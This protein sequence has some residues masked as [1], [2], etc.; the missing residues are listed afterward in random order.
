VNHTIFSKGMGNDL[1]LN[2]ASCRHFTAPD[3]TNE[4]FF[5]QLPF[6]P[7]KEIT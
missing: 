4:D 1:K 6:S 2:G 5:H 3:G 7:S